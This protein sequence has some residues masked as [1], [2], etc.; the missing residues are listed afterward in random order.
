MSHM[1]WVHEWELY[2][3]LTSVP[4]KFR[5]TQNL[6]MC[7]CL[8]IGLCRYDEEEVILAKAGRYSRAWCSYKEWEI[9]TQRH[10]ERIHTHAHTHAHI[11]D[12][13]GKAWN[14]ASTIQKMPG[15]SGNPQKL[16][17]RQNRFSLRTTENDP[18]LLTPSFLDV[19]LQ[20]WETINL[21]YFKLLSLWHFVNSSLRKLMYTRHGAWHMP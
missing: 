16:E 14:D 3:R 6:G 15:L 13:R 12:D 2:S 11:C 9:Q 19:C 21:C 20:N 1:E 7:P 18:A 17:E 4:L 10:T 8:K 5:P